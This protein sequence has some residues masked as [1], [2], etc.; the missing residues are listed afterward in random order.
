MAGDVLLRVI[1]LGLLLMAA[2]LG[3]PAAGQ[4]ALEIIA[5]RHRTAEQV[6]P[7]LRPLMEPGS[8]LTGHGT[9]L[10]VRTSP[11]NLHELRRALQAI[12]R[13]ARRLQISVRVDDALE[14]SVQG[15]EAGGRVSNRGARVD[16]RANERRGSASERVD[17]RIQVLEGARAYIS[18]GQSTPVFGGTAT[19]DTQ[20]GFEAVPR[21]AGENV[22]VELIQRRDTAAAQQGVSSTV[23][24]RLGEW[25]EVAGLAEQGARDERGIASR[26]TGRS[27]EA[28][29]I[30]LKVDEIAP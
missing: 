15:V 9:Q 14:Q 13:P 26:S 11:A 21:L 17:Q 6:L 30:W 23:S 5:L 8:T 10:I 27:V 20:T 3:A 2:L 24:A 4:G 12:D 7:A 25:F 16:V 22:I 18:T 28:R 29:R 1:R 19:H